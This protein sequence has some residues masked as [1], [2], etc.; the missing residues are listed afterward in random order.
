MLNDDE[1]RGLYIFNTEKGD[2]FHCHSLGLFT[3]GQFH[4]IGIDSVFSGVNL[5][6]YNVTG[7]DGDIGKFKTPSLK[8]IALTGPYMHDG[9]FKTL[10][11]V[12][13]FY[14]SQV[15]KSPSLDPIMSKPSFK[16]GLQLTQQDK[17][18]LLA[19]LKALT[20]SAFIHNPA[21]AAP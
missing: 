17:N 4:N 2:C 19:F 6:R 5:G 20:D 11:E 7:E 8:N 14:N 21:L 15:R 9:R 12:I 16:Y 10:E 13:E 1:L 18:D 3:D